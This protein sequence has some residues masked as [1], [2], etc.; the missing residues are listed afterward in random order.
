MPD[1][2]TIPGGPSFAGN[3]QP[4]DVPCDPTGD[5]WRGPPGPPGPMGTV[6]GASLPLARPDG[7]PPAG[8]ASGS[9]YNNGGFVCVTP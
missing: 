3:P 4:P 2:I 7:S 8:A 5:G 9:F 6:G 1:G